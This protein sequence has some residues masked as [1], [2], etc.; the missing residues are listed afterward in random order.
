[1]TRARNNRRRNLFKVDVPVTVELA[2]DKAPAC[3]YNR[4]DDA[5]TAVLILPL[6]VPLPA[7]LCGAEHLSYRVASGIVRI[8]G[9]RSH[10][11]ACDSKPVERRCS[12]PSVR[13]GFS[14]AH[15][16]TVGPGTPSP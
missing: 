5:T 2:I 8:L 16:R 7:P 12:D 4:D 11:V 10:Q 3:D 15:K 9:V 14:H 13:E 6:K 1:M